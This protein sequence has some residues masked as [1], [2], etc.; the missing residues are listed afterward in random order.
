MGEKRRGD[1]YFPCNV[2]WGR[3]EGMPLK[4][5]EERTRGL[6]NLWTGKRLKEKEGQKLSSLLIGGTQPRGEKNCLRG[7]PRE[8]LNSSGGGRR[9]D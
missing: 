2:W 3:L 8:R 5:R 7:L 1:K 6:A 4:E 9:M